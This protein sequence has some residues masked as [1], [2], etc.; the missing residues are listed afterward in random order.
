L[1]LGSYASEEELKTGSSISAFP[2]FGSKQRSLVT[3]RKSDP[4]SNNTFAGLSSDPRNIVPTY[5][6]PS[7][8]YKNTLNPD[9]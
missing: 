5:P 7:S 1:P 2:N 8:F 6:A 3:A 4:V 9:F